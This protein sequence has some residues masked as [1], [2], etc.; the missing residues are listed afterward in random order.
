MDGIQPGWEL[1]V[2]RLAYTYNGHVKGHTVMTSFRLSLACEPPG[3][4]LQGLSTALPHNTSQPIP[5]KIFRLYIP[6]RPSF[7]SPE[8]DKMLKAGKKQYKQYSYQAI[9]NLSM[10]SPGD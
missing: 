9:R 8:T 5:A 7:M 6:P 10:F 3:P 1:F 4:T 2:H